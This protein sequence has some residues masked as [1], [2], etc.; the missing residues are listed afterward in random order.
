[1]G[2]APAFR[3][4]L[5]GGRR[6]KARLFPTSLQAARV[7]RLLQGRGAKD[8]PRPMRRAGRV[9]V[10]EF[11]KGES[12]DRLLSK[13][14]PGVELR[15]ARAAG[16]LLAR[17]HSGAAAPVVGPRP[18]YYRARMRRT[19]RALARAGLLGTE[20][21]RCLARLEAPPT[22]RAGVTHGDLCPE[23][24]VRMPSGRLRAIDEERLAVRP[25]AFDLARTVTRWPLGPALE[26]A[27]LDGY[28]AGGGNAK[29]YN[30]R[31]TFWVA[32]ALATSAD[33]RL[34]RHAGALAVPVAGLR[35]LAA[36]LC[37]AATDRGR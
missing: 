34:L 5:A 31:R 36:T 29:G 14:A 25:L 21:A 13:A 17:L 19:V 28:T 33:H 11:V 32:A 3:L 7:S 6:L 26:A 4:D 30:A 22:A 35:R 37:A 16:A 2:Q 9:L 12:L 20:H 27:L 10:V 23:N 15:Q 8:L 18:A 24:L 1:M